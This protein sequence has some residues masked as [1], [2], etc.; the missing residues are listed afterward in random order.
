[1]K[2]EVKNT[3][4]IFLYRILRLTGFKFYTNN[5][6][7]KEIV[8]ALNIKDKRKRLEYIYD[9]AIRYVN[10][11]YSDDLCKFENDQCIAQRKNGGNEINGCCK[12]CHL[13]TDNGC[14]SVNLPC[15]L[16]YCKTAIG[17]MNLLKLNDI[18][19]IK[20]LTLGQRMVLS[21][22]FFNTKEDILKDLNNGIIYS[23]FRSLKTSLFFNLNK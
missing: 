14:P 11:Y 21:S 19:I 10:K 3:K 17:N 15:K 2:V 1:M 8:K 7:Y 6:E 23:T 5:K 20:C 18:P 22:S 12:K 4:L 13:V 16:I 9:E